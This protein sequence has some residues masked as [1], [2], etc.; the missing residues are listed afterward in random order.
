MAT[1]I[2][3]RSV[4]WGGAFSADGAI[5]TF[6]SLGV[7]MLAQSINWS[8]VQNVQRIYEIGSNSVYLI[9]GRTQGTAGVNRIMGPTQV[10]SS[11][12]SS[13]GD[14]CQAYRN[15][16]TFQAYARC[17]VNGSGASGQTVNITLGNC[18]IQSYGGGVQA[19]QMVVNEQI[20]MMF[21][22]L[23]YG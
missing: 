8:Y 6:G 7:G 22:Y 1:D 14:V 9:A 13:F 2:Y 19:E 12:Y 5:I 16:I 11:F 21:I 20:Q 15:N 3:S 18:V 10:A 17:G 23:T 4:N